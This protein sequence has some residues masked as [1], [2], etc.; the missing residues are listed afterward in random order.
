[1]LPQTALGP[2]PGP[3]ARAAGGRAVVRTILCITGNGRGGRFVA[4]NCR[5]IDFEGVEARHFHLIRFGLRFAPTRATRCS[6]R[7]S[8]QLLIWIR[9][10]S[11]FTQRGGTHET[12]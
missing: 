2:F 3:E 12:V 10:I 9:I 4:M 6:V 7:Y 1:V 8:R 11:I 5:R